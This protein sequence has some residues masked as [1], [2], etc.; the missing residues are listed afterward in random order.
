M[1]TY[2]SRGFTTSNKDRT[3]KK[4]LRTYTQPRLI[5]IAW[6]IYHRYH[7]LLMPIFSIIDKIEFYHYN[8]RIEKE[9]QNRQTGFPLDGSDILIP[10]TA[11]QDINCH[12]LKELFVKEISRETII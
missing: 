5:H 3:Q 2:T 8:K 9:V 10:L 7:S 6:Q 1:A 12:H 4:Y 11:R